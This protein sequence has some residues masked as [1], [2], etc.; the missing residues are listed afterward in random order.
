MPTSLN[1]LACWPVMRDVVFP[2]PGRAKS[3]P[4]LFDWGGRWPGPTGWIPSVLGGFDAWKFA[5]EFHFGFEN[6]LWNQMLPALQQQHSGSVWFQK[7]IRLT[8]LILDYLNSVEALDFTHW[9]QFWIWDCSQKPNVG[10]I[11]TTEFWI[12]VEA[13]RRNDLNCLILVCF[14]EFGAWRF[15]VWISLWAWHFVLEDHVDNIAAKE[16]WVVV[17]FNRWIHLK[18]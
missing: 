12:L 13:N 18:F 6:P 16:L 9:F 1:I 15:A 17:D 4:I 2:A 11:A 3:S 7:I 10:N 14:S 8:V 5:I